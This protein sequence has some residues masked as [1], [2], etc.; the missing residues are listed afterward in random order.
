MCIWALGLG[1]FVPIIVEDSVEFGALGF[2]EHGVELFGEWVSGEGWFEAFAECREEDLGLGRVALGHCVGDGADR[3]D[4]VDE[5]DGEGKGAFVVEIS[6]C[7][8]VVLVVGDEHEGGEFW[9]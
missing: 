2:V 4:L 7:G 5:E 8:E 1:P 3:V 9:A 6:C